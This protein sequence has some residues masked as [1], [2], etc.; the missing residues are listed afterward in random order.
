M[1]SAARQAPSQVLAPGHAARVASAPPRPPP[2]RTTEITTRWRSVRG[3]ARR[4]GSPRAA[5]IARQ[6]AKQ[7]S[8]RL[9]ITD[10]HSARLVARDHYATR[11]AATPIAAGLLRRTT[12]SLG[13]RADSQVGG[14]R[15]TLPGSPR[16][17]MHACRERCFR[18]SSRRVRPAGAAPRHPSGA[19]APKADAAAA[20]ERAR[21]QAAHGAP[22]PRPRGPTAHHVH[23][24][25][26]MRGSLAVRSGAPASTNRRFLRRAIG[27]L[28]VRSVNAPAS[29]PN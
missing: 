18:S 6:R 20:R 23:Q 25:E 24:I 12:R 5:P 15:R 19:T 4:D 22:A 26:P 13:R 2:A 16:E 1:A 9:V 14:R 3:T 7:A 21:L 29:P 27:R 11:L 8:R 10:E 28:D 17:P